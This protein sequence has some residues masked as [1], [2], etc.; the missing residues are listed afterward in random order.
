MRGAYTAFLS[1]HQT[2]RVRKCFSWLLFFSPLQV[3]LMR[4]QSH[5]KFNKAGL[6]T[7][8]RDEQRFPLNMARAFMN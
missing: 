3:H 2:F 8:Q 5:T 4:I 6:S 7:K 1:N